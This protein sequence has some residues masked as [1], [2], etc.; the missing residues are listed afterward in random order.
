VEEPLGHRRIAPGLDQD[1]EDVS[2]LVDRT[3][4]IVL[5]AANADEHLVRLVVRRP[6]QGPLKFAIDTVIRYY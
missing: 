1:V 2:V 4:K 6:R 5:L 3:P